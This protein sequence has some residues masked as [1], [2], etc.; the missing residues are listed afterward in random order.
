MLNWQKTIRDDINYINCIPVYVRK[1][2]DENRV[3]LMSLDFDEEDNVLWWDAN[4][5]Y[6]NPIFFEIDGTEWAYTDECVKKTY[7]RKRIGLTIK[8]QEYLEKVLENFEHDDPD[9]QKICNK[10][11]T[12]IIKNLGPR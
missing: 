5:T 8:E 2:N 7:P 6:E 1:T 12:K 3:R 4:S 10:I 11:L 9:A